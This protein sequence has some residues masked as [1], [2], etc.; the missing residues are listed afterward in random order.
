MLHSWAKKQFLMKWNNW[1]LFERITGDTKRSLVLLI[2][3]A[4]KTAMSRGGR[5]ILKRCYA[6]RLRIPDV[7][8]DSVPSRPLS[9]YLQHS[10]LSLLSQLIAYSRACASFVAVQAQDT[11]LISVTGLNFWFLINPTRRFS[12]KCN[13]PQRIRSISF[14]HYRPIS[15]NAM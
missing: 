6:K 10:V 2:I 11:A 3:I 9:G 12:K 8:A 4:G 13:R 7:L 14:L 5:H 1:W 15:F